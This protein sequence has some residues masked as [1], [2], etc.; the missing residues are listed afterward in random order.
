M[1]TLRPF[2]ED[3]L[4]EAEMYLAMQKYWDDQGS[5]W[6]DRIVT[7]TGTWV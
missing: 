3:D 6:S 5:Y 1:I 2:Y 4:L 7:G